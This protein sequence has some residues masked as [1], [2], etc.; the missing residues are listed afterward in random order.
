[1]LRGEAMKWPR[2]FLECSV[3]AKIRYRRYPYTLFP[4]N[5]LQLNPAWLARKEK[6]DFLS[7]FSLTL[8][9]RRWLTTIRQRVF[10][11]NGTALA[12]QRICIYRKLPCE[13]S[14]N[15]VSQDR[16]R[17]TYITDARPSFSLKRLL[18]ARAEAEKRAQAQDLP[19]TEKGRER[20]RERGES[21]TMRPLLTVRTAQCANPTN[22]FSLSLENTP[23]RI[24]VCQ[25]LNLSILAPFISLIGSRCL[26]NLVN[27]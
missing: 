8:R 10:T 17:L 16:S 9:L 11:E 6:G 5:C 7:L 3:P 15:C 23:R 13:S 14:F 26:K 18:R 27:A 25:S 19:A 22:L 1:M 24:G 21:L 2:S 4:A 12:L 20:E